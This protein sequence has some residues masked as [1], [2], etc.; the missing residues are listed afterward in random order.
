[1]EWMIEKTL[2]PRKNINVTV[3]GTPQIQLGD[4]VT[5]NYDMPEGVKFVD[6]SKQFVVYAMDHSRNNA[7][8]ST[9]LGLSE[10]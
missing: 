2:R 5:I 9:T 7:G 10:V 1:M 8:M 4:I 3:F 6:P